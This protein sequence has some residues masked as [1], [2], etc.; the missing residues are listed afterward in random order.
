MK[1]FGQNLLG[2]G[3]R[4]KLINV[5]PVFLQHHLLSQLKISKFLIYNVIIDDSQYFF[6]YPAHSLKY[7]A[8]EGV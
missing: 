3:T 8:F 1:F 2:F 7:D 4:C 5:F 6:F